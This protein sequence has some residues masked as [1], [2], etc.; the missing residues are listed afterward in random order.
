MK[1]AL[2]LAQCTK[3]ATATAAAFNPASVALYQPEARFFKHP[4]HEL[5]ISKARNL[6]HK[7]VPSSSLALS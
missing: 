6:V 1:H 7:F 4:G 2:S 3:T 5:G